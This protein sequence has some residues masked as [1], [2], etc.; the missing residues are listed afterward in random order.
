MRSSVRVDR[1]RLA[2]LLG[3]LVF[4]PRIVALAQLNLSSRSTREKAAALVCAHKLVV[5]QHKACHYVRES[6]LIWCKGP[7]E[8]QNPPF[9]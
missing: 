6:V 1:V 5:G 9:V 4:S 3:L 2:S 8:N 7:L